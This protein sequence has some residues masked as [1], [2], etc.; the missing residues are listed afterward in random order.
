MITGNRPF[1]VGMVLA[2]TWY[3]PAGFIDSELMTFVSTKPFFFHLP[4]LL[5]RPSWGVCQY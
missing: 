1:M 5:S 3:A 2:S 4:L